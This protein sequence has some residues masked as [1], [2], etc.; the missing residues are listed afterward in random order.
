M[1]QNAGST[2]SPIRWGV[3]WLIAIV[4]LIAILTPKLLWMNSGYASLVRSW[5]IDAQF[6]IHPT[7]RMLLVLV[8]W[9]LVLRLS[10]TGER[11]TMGLAIG[12]RRVLMGIM[13]GMVCTLPMLV[14][15]L[16]SESFTPSRIEIIHTAIAP[17]LTEE[18]FFR[19]F[20]FGLLVQVAR[21]P[22]WTTAIITGIVFGLA[23]VDLTPDEGQTILGQLGPWIALI[24]VGGF[25]YAWLY[26]SSGWN[27]WLVIALHTGMNMWWDMFDLNATPLGIWG[28]TAARVLCVLLAVYLVVGRRALGT[29][30]GATIAHERSP[31]TT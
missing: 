13:V 8:G 27:L 25:M 16:M 7:I 9:V 24:G 21:T 26:F 6:M 30:G 14:L 18:I 15:G 28:A 22:M 1:A 11:M 23:H 2:A 17:G 29:P 12:R 19:A 20:M 31:T 4:S 3:V 10:P 5:P